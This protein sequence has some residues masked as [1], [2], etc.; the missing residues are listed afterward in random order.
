MNLSKRTIFIAGLG[1]V[2]AV[3]AIAL[4]FRSVKA[5]ALLVGT[6]PAS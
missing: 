5:K 4:M 3:V 2:L 6:T 1:A